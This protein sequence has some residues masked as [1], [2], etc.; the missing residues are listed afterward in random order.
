MVQNRGSIF[1]GVILLVVG[2]IFLV[3]QF[4]SINIWAVVWPV[5]LILVGLWLLLGRRRF[6]GAVGNSSEQVV[7]F[8]N[9]AVGSVAGNSAVDGEI[10][11]ESRP[12]FA[13]NRVKHKGFGNLTLIQGDREELTIDAPD[14]MRSNIRSEVKN[15]TLVIYH[16]VNGWDWL[17]FGFWGANHVE[18]RLTM[19]DIAGLD[20]SGAGNV[21]CNQ[22]K[23][24]RLEI[25]RSG[26]GNMTLSGLE[27]D[28]LSVRQHGAGNI[29]LSGHAT[30]QDLVFSGAGNYHAE[31][32][33][34]KTVKVIQS[35]VG[36]T[37]VWATDNLD[38]NMSGVGNVEYYGS[39]SINRRASG[40]GNIRGLGNR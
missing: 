11:G 38:I 18:Y 29:S 39:P 6:S 26:A 40:V 15:G 25:E 17:D 9:P 12:V 4:F 19:R 10:T 33:E 16:D 27:L 35:G 14:A 3:G 13:F 1:F 37:T 8:A 32:L 28:Q 34:S 22:I 30:D 36:N 31:N 7:S 20:I 21:V 2:L 5:I 23:G 24:S